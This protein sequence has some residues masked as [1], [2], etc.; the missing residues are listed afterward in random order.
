MREQPESKTDRGPFLTR[1]ACQTAS[2]ANTDDFSRPVRCF[3][4]LVVWRTVCLI[5]LATGK[6][7]ARSAESKTSALR[8]LLR[9]HTSPVLSS[10]R[11]ATS[12]PYAIAAAASTGAR[13][14]QKR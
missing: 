4:S 6:A 2:T 7:L 3:R 8:P 10:A 13:A 1:I 12:A 5:M 14:A 11:L 9:K